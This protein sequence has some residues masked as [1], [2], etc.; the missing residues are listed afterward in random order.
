MASTP[1]KGEIAAPLRGASLRTCVDDSATAAETA[2]DIKVVDGKVTFQINTIDADDVTAGA[3]RARTVKAIG[4]AKVRFDNS[5]CTGILATG[6][7]AQ[8]DTMYWNDVDKHFTVTK[9][10]ANSTNIPVG[11]VYEDATVDSS[12]IGEVMFSIEPGATF[13]VA[14]MT[15][16]ES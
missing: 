13:G 8:N 12:T 6:F 11:L 9:T 2:G 16:D 1:H 4:L 5:K 10:D 3:P 7:Y 14:S 15:P